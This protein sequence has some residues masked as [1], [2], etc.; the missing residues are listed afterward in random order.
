MDD[1]RLTIRQGRIKWTIEEI[2]KTAVFAKAAFSHQESEKW[3][4]QKRLS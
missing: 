1:V 3:N 2:K 4:R